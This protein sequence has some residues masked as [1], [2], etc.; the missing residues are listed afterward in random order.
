MS[1][2]WECRTSDRRTY[3]NVSHSWFG[4]WST[5]DIFTRFVLHLIWACLNPGCF[6]LM[7]V[8]AAFRRRTIGCLPVD[9]WE[10]LMILM[11]SALALLTTLWL[12]WQWKRSL[13][14]SAWWNIA[15]LWQGENHW[16]LTSST[17]CRAPD[18]SG[19]QADISRELQLLPDLR[20]LLLWL[21]TTLPPLRSSSQPSRLPCC[22]F[23]FSSIWLQLRSRIQPPL[24]PVSKSPPSFS[25]HLLVPT[26][27]LY[28]DMWETPALHPQVT[29]QPQP[30]LLLESQPVLCFIIIIVIIIIIIYSF[31]NLSLFFFLYISEFMTDNRDYANL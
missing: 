10:T 23:F 4:C 28:V 22:S 17:C 9:F 30:A 21:K 1:P 18:S 25:P 31:V 16:L 20:A 29:P 2:S 19:I 5:A 8:W 3:R 14:R 6:A 12:H 7:I 15:V 13:P 11:W 24:L 26:K 27:R